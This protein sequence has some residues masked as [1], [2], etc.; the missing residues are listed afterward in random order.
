MK[1]QLT[2]LYA[3]INLLLSIGM[4]I[5]VLN[6][7]FQS[8]LAWGLIG[9]LSAGPLF[10]LTLGLLNSQFASPE[11]AD[12]SDGVDESEDTACTTKTKEDDKD[13]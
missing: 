1:P 2:P 11:K 12:P 4:V 6:L 8:G 10:V 13:I 7:A 5:S 9:I 3:I